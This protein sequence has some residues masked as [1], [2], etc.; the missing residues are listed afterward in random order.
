MATI[1]PTNNRNLIGP[2]QELKWEI[3]N[4]IT[5]G[6]GADFSQASGYVL[7]V[8]LYNPDMLTP[9]VLVGTC[10]HVVFEDGDDT[11]QAVADRINSTVGSDVA[12]TRNNGTRLSLRYATGIETSGFDLDTFIHIGLLSRSAW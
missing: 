9:S 10:Y 5:D 12:A 7:D 4:P 2:V 6:W 11:A 8:T 3:K 1:Y